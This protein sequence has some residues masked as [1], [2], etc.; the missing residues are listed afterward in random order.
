M[1]ERG[2]DH[3]E[4]ETKD[5]TKNHGI[6]SL[7]DLIFTSLLQMALVPRLTRRHQREMLIFR[8]HYK[9]KESSHESCQQSDYL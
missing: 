2:I 1:T 3:E 9:N 5:I 7:T 6:K 4:R 8:L